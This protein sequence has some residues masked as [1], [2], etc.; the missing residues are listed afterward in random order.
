[1]KISERLVVVWLVLMLAMTPIEAQNQNGPMVPTTSPAYASG[2]L[3]LRNGPTVTCL[4]DSECQQGSNANPAGSTYFNSQYVVGTAAN[5]ILGWLQVVSGGAFTLDFLT[6]GYPGNI[7]GLIY[8]GILTQG[9]GCPASTSVTVTPSTPTGSPAHTPAN[10]SFTTTAAGLTPAVG[11]RFYETVGA[12]QG[13]GYNANPT[14]T[15]SQSC[16]VPPTFFYA[17]NGVG[18]FGTNGDTTAGMLQRVSDVCASQPDYVIFVGGTNDLAAGTAVSA[19][20][21]NTLAIMQGLEACGVRVILM[22]VSPRTIGIGG[23]TST[24]DKARLRVN[25]Y[26]RNLANLTRLNQLAGT[27]NA[28]I[29]GLPY[30]LV[31]AEIDHY[32]TDAI[33]SGATIGNALLTCTFDGLHQSPYGAMAYG[34]A[35]WHEIKGVIP[36]PLWNMPNSQNDLYD[37]TNNPDGNLLGGTVGLMLGTTG[38]ATAPCTTSSAL[39]ASWHLTFAAGTGAATTNVSCVGTLETTRTDGLPG[40]RQIVTVSDASTNTSAD[41]VTF[42]LFS[43][44]TASL[45]TGDLVYLEGDVD[46]SNAVQL[47]YV[48]CEIVETNTINQVSES[49]L[50]GNYSNA[51]GAIALP[52][53]AKLATWWEAKNLPDWQLTATGSYRMH[54]RTHPIK[55]QASDTGWTEQCITLFN[56]ATGTATATFKFSDF[57]IRKLNV[58]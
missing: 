10:L 53:S 20:N 32:C 16:T 33:Q 8:A 26:R 11:T 48:G 58:N 50:G 37:A 38:T 28:A 9:T 13:S 55:V 14:F 46:I 18:G 45:S 30:P 51:N 4:G 29:S 2:S 39:A 31:Y 49:L 36:A 23:W 57:A 6:Q 22:G 21:A 43:N 7:N 35:I 19:I 34:L 27:T 41:N 17:L 40:Q 44:I 54:I 42:A 24:M 47:M 12:N 25:Q 5:S 1:M 15:L 56:G 52:T 3:P